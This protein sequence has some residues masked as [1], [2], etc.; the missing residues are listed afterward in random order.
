MCAHSQATLKSEAKNTSSS[1]FSH[2]SLFYL[3]SYFNVN[4]VRDLPKRKNHKAARYVG[5]VEEW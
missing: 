2:F 5:L 1:S 4:F 3:F